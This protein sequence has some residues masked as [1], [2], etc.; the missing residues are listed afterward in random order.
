VVSG[1]TYTKADYNAGITKA[2]TNPPINPL[3]GQP[4]TLAYRR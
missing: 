1:E 4:A 2:N 3:T